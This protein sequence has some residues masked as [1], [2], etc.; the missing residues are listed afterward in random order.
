MCFFSENL[1][2]MPHTFF[3]GDHQRMFPHLQERIVMADADKTINGHV[4]VQYY[5]T[6]IQL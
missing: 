2:Y 6:F 4:Q 3:I 5:V 1:A